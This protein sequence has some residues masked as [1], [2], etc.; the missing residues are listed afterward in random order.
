VTIERDRRRDASATAA[1]ILDAAAALFAERGF[2]RTTVRDIAAHAEVNQALL[3]R[4]FGSKE[5]L[6][7]QVMLRGGREQLASTPPERLP[8][9]VLRAMLYSGERRDH[10]LET[11]LRSIAGER[12]ETAVRRQLGEE[13]TAALAGLTGS[14]DAELRADL[15]LAWLVGIGLIRN[16][17]GKEPL[18]NADPEKVVEL[19]LT[20]AGSLLENLKS[21]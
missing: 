2:E 3:F 5:A 19:V 20:A 10:A 6:F 15:M 7:E 8:E 16:V 14:A 21:D 17:A 9:A 18:A 11:F 4:Y 12:E 1:A 13:Y